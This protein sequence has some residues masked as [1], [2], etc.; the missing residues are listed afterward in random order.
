FQG[1]GLLRLDSERLKGRLVQGGVGFRVQHIVTTFDAEEMLTQ[2]KAS[3]MA[4]HPGTR[5]A[6]CHANVQTQTSGLGKIIVDPRQNR[7]ICNEGV[8]TLAL[9]RLDSRTIDSASELL[10]EIC[11]WV[12]GPYGANTC[13]PYCK[14]ERAPMRLVDLLPGLK[15]G[16]FRIQ[17]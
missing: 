3:E 1:N 14:G 12:K 15:F 11:V 2:L 8:T 10:L 7:L 4:M 5:G 16:Q 17:N 9:L 6:G 13:S